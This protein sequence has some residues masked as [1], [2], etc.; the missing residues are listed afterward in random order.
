MAAREEEGEK[1]ETRLAQLKN[2][3]AST[4]KALLN[5]VMPGWFAEISQMWP[6]QAL[7]LKVKETLFHARS[8]YQDVLVFSSETYGNVLVLDG[9]IQCT[10]RDEFSYQEM[11]T[12]LPICSLP[13]PAKKVLVIGGGDGGVLREITRHECIE[14]IEI[15]ELDEMVPQVAKKFFPKM[16][17]GFDDP[18][19][20]CHFQDG[21]K[22]LADVE[23]GTYDAIIVDSS[24]PV[25]PAASLFQ[26][27]FFDLVHR[28]LADDGIVCTQAESMWLHMD[29]IQELHQLCLEVFSSGSVNYAYC[30]IPTY[31]SGQIGFMLSSKSSKRYNEPQQSSPSQSHQSSKI[32]PLKY[33]NS[34]IHKASFVLPQF[35]KEA[36][37][38]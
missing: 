6:G 38:Q 3:Q 20:K 12:H 34:D 25:G 7:S 35:A 28:A 10:D 29:I 17:V 15:C 30:T 24:D 26:K 14:T 4:A 36:L 21:F 9:V 32:G 23:P 19:V 16:A 1:E 22:F 8:K 2:A 33:Y 31:P 27:P 5:G 18:R 37:G 11:I 13:R